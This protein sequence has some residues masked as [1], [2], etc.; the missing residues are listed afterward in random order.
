MILSQRRFLETYKKHEYS[1]KKE[2]VNARRNGCR[3]NHTSE[4]IAADMDVFLSNPN[5]KIYKAKFGETNFKNW[6]LRKS[7]AMATGTE[8][9][10]TKFYGAK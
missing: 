10:K 5:N 7:T 8:K 2:E 6:D 9:N 3:V 1:I 4:Q